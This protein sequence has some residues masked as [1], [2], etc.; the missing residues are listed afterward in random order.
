MSKNFSKRNDQ[1]IKPSPYSPSSDIEEEGIRC[2][3]NSI[4]FSRIKPH[5]AEGDK[6]PNHDG[7]IEILDFGHIPVGKMTV[8]LKGI[9]KG[10]SK[11]QC[12][13]ETLAYSHT[14][15]EPFL[16][17]C[18]DYANKKVYW[19]QIYYDMPEAK[20]RQDSFVIH[21]AEADTI[22]SEGAYIGKWINLCKEYQRIHSF[23]A[24]KS[25]YASEQI[26]VFQK[27]VDS[28]NS[29]LDGPWKCIK[30]V[31]FY[32]TWKIGLGMIALG[33]GRVKYSLFRVP[34]GQAS[35]LLATIP[36]NLP[37]GNDKFG[38][39]DFGVYNNTIVMNDCPYNPRQLAEVAGPE[40]V[41]QYCIDVALRSYRFPIVNETLAAEIVY[42]FVRH[43]ASLLKIDIAGE[44]DFQDIRKRILS[45]FFND[46]W[47][48]KNQ[49]EVKSTLFQS[50]G[51]YCF[52]KPQAYQYV[53]TIFAPHEPWQDNNLSLFPVHAIYESLEL[54]NVQ[55]L[56]AEVPLPDIVSMHEHPVRH[57]SDQCELAR[58]EY[59]AKNLVSVY[60][61]FLV[62]NG[63]E[64]LNSP[65]LD[66]HLA[67]VFTYEVRP[68]ES[69]IPDIQ[70][71]T[72]LA[73]HSFRNDGTFPS[74]G[75]LADSD[76]KLEELNKN[77]SF[78]AFQCNMFGLYSS[79]PL[80]VSVYVLLKNDIANYLRTPLI[81]PSRHY[82][83]RKLELS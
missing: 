11:F 30:N 39:A 22:D 26:A 12:K 19:K 2:F 6:T 46:D 80:W 69:N 67:H 82:H 4:D 71:V 77:Y 68:H 5:V 58:A 73:I 61:D 62:K 41:R 57:M 75:L 42:S 21:F 63:L 56:R 43:Y 18:V 47:L 8:Q 15:S 70:Y 37:V 48:Q 79:M 17:I 28:I 72:G 44:Y 54:L 34:Y 32:N 55:Y 20:D 27:M 31:I 36:D 66:D 24:E 65:F 49:R 76:K 50:M 35:S 9:P 60:R 3:Y 1:L 16:L 40:F 53:S 78:H 81:I 83:H 14:L 51:A 59:I 23:L 33:N 7:F 74:V 52:V 38:E 25:Q 13:M 10:E 64:F 29:A 45:K